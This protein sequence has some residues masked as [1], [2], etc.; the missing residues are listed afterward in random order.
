MGPIK[1]PYVGSMP[2][3]L[4][5]HID[6]GSSGNQLRFALLVH[7]GSCRGLRVRVHGA[8]LGFCQV[9]YLHLQPK[10][11]HPGIE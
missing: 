7:V 10:T 1:V 11:F 5:N 4:T 2:F 9:V 6:C 8:R 3:W